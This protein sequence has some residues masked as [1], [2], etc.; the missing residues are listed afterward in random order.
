LDEET[1]D[2]E[3]Q[4]DMTITSKWAFVRFKTEEDAPRD[5]L[6]KKLKRTFNPRWQFWRIVN[7]AGETVPV[8]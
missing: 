3:E 1:A 7:K 4:E 2:E 5:L 8:K 6:I